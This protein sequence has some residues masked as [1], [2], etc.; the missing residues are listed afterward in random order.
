M[1]LVVIGQ[2]YTSPT[3]QFYHKLKAR[4]RVTLAGDELTQE[5]FLEASNSRPCS[6]VL[7]STKPL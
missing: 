6:Y 7:T 5:L 2:T 4:S 3:L 1:N